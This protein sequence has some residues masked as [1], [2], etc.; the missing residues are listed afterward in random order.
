M[1]GYP[2]ILFK[3]YKAK[4]V[5]I[6]TNLLVLIAIGTY[7]RLRV[8]T[9]KR[10]T[11]YTLGDL[12]MMLRILAYFDRCLTTPNILTEVDNL[13]RQLPEAEHKP[14]AD[15][16]SQLISRQFE[17]YLGSHDV[18]QHAAY[19]RLGLTDCATALAAAERNVLVITDD[20]R[21]SNILSGLDLDAININ[22]IRTL[23]W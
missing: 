15:A 11:Q 19:S 4:G 3:K 5:L 2:A 17:I 13:T 22:H 16:F 14:L 20:L 10:T 21:L 1:P 9:F 6:D 12:E 7:N 23:N 18:A 8:G